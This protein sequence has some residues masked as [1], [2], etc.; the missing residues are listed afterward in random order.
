MLAD[1]AV[2]E[3]LHRGQA[4]G[5]GE[6]VPT[7][8]GAVVARAHEV[9]H[10][11]ARRDGAHGESVG[12]A[13][14]HGH[15]VGLDL[16]ALVAEG[17]PAAI[18]A[19]LH[20]VDDQQDV[21]LGAELADVA[22]VVVVGVPDA[23]LAL[24][25]LE[26]DGARRALARAAHGLAQRVDV[27]QGH[28]HK[29][30]G[31]GPE[32]LVEL[33]LPGGG[34]GRERATVEALARGHD[35]VG[36]A[37]LALAPAARDLDGALVG[38][39]AGVGEEGLPAGARG[40]HDVAALIGGGGEHGGDGSGQA[41]A[42]LVVEVVARLPD[43]VELLDDSLLHGRVGVAQARAAD[44][45]EQVDVLLARGVHERG[46][47]PGDELHGIAGVRGH[48][49]GGIRLGDPVLDGGKGGR[50]VVLLVG[51]EASSPRTR[52]V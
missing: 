7:E 2:D 19:R 28:R 18:E 9:G 31:H 52:P 47:V 41:H 8:R 32:A 25:A 34:K 12:D 5:A 6:V 21:L 10:A 13:L 42:V 33:V 3:L 49:V 35:G 37:Q 29:A 17:G 26:H 30:G 44:A 38:L 14:G 11:G 46:I 20:L 40:A 16:A 24:H 4:R 1:L 23:A 43:A 45:A 39:G 22:H 27:V 36:P 51:H 15:D 50:A 48:D